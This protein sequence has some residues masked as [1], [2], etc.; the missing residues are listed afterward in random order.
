M[1]MKKKTPKENRIMCKCHKCN[2]PYSYDNR[3]GYWFGN[4]CRSCARPKKKKGW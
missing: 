4:L 1:I 2:K 3:W